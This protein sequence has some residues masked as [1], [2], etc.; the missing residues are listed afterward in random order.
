MTEGIN[1]TMVQVDVQNLGR[2]YICTYL[3]NQVQVQK[4][5][6]LSSSEFSHAYSLLI[7]CNSNLEPTSIPAFQRSFSK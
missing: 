2:Y 5:V 6:N 1:G 3:E 7:K 4:M